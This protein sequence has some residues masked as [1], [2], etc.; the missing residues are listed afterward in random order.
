MLLTASSQSSSHYSDPL[1]CDH[2]PG[3]WFLTIA[4][5]GGH[6]IMI[7]NLPCWLPT[8]KSNGESWQEV[9][10][11]NQV[12]Y[13]LNNLH[14]G[15]QTC[16]IM[17]AS[18]DISGLFFPLRQTVRGHGQCT[19]H[20]TC[21]IGVW[22]YWSILNDTTSISRKQ[23]GILFPFPVR[24]QLKQLFLELISNHLMLYG[25]MISTRNNVKKPFHLTAQG[26]FEYE[27]F[28]LLKLENEV[29]LLKR[30]SNHWLFLKKNFKIKF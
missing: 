18:C 14:Q 4:I 19:M 12:R 15:C 26:Y 25:H 29:L 8:S 10:S 3:T 2:D 6:T 20:P 13:S 27:A 24:C 17:L 22:Q 28:L 1:A 9:G 7:Y 5:S 21:G 30:K 23:D 16:I 11:C